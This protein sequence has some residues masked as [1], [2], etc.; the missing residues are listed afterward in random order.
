MQKTGYHWTGVFQGLLDTRREAVGC[1]A[2][3]EHD[4]LTLHPAFLDAAVQTLLLAYFY[5]GDGR[6]RSLLFPTGIERVGVD[7]AGWRGLREGRLGMERGLTGGG[8]MPF[9]SV[10]DGL[11]G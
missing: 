11:S 8:K 7:L 3:P 2:L 5:P 1:L 9:Y 4:N 10:V 6:L